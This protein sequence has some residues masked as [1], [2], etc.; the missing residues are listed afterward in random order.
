VYLSLDPEGQVYVSGEVA[1]A[2]G[3]S[4]LM[5]LLYDT[6]GQLLWETFYD[7]PAREDI[8][9]DLRADLFG[10][11]YLTGKSQSGGSGQYLTLKYE[12]MPLAPQVVLGPTGKASHVANEVL[13]RFDP[14]VVDA[15]FV[16][17]RELNFGRVDEIIT[18]PSLIFLMDSKLQANGQLGS[19]TLSRIFHSL[20]T[21]DE[22][23]T[24]VL[25][26]TVELPK[27]WSAL[28]LHIPPSPLESITDE[29]EVA[30][31][32]STIPLRYIRYAHPSYYLHL[33][34]CAPND[35]RYGNQLS[36]NN[37]DAVRTHV[38]AEQAWCF[39]DSTDAQK[40][41]P[42]VRVGIFDTGISANH[43][44]FVFGGTG[45]AG[46][47][48]DLA[49]RFVNGTQVSLQYSDPDLQGHGSKSSG[50]IAAIR[51][52]GM[53]IAGIAGGDVGKGEGEGVH[54]VNVQTFFVDALGNASAKIP[55]LADAFVWAL[56]AGPNNSPL[57]EVANHG[58]GF[59][60]NDIQVN[61]P[62]V[63]LYREVWQMAF[64]AEVTSVVSRGNAFQAAPT[65]ASSIPATFTIDSI[66]EPSFYFD[67]W[68]LSVGASDEKGNLA[69]WQK[70]GNPD[71]FSSYYKKSVDLITPGVSSRIETTNHTGGY[72]DFNGTS[73]SAPHVSGAAALL[74]SYS[75]VPL[76]PEDV[77]HLLQYGAIPKNNVDSAGWGLL[78][79][80]ASLKL[81]EQPEHRVL[82]FDT[83]LTSGAFPATPGT[84]PI[85]L[86]SDYDTISAGIYQA[87]VYQYV[88][89][90]SYN[91]GTGVSLAALPPNKPPYW[92][93]NS[94]S[95]LWGPNGTLQGGSSQ[96]VV[97]VD[98]VSF[99][100]T[101]TVSSA[102]VSGYYYEIFLSSTESVV[103]PYGAD[104]S[105]QM[106]FSL[107]AYNPEGFTT[108]VEESFLDKGLSLHIFP[109]PTTEGSTLSYELTKP[110]DVQISLTDLSG[111]ILWQ[112]HSG[113]KPQGIHRQ[114]VPSHNLSTGLYLLRFQ[115]DGFTS[116]VKL[117]KQ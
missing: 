21:Q 86:T 115:A 104:T 46:S 102:S 12:V 63:D 113:R 68:N 109:N 98:R 71:P 61:Q 37:N 43:P 32:L 73:A 93:R 13:I 23:M 91:L 78:D 27:L 108:N 84:I 15:A 47:V 1:Q 31:S 14:S 30:D 39:L 90:F 16:D 18:D 34:T 3:G 50:I 85:R 94:G 95:R 110:A 44:D 114:E 56:T 60:L 52:N 2:G 58:Y 20:D 70:P 42:D 45:F 62:N 36:L 38:N 72:S 29:H 65:A 49:Q 22:T 111:R 97:P 87:N 106:A 76:A 89:S 35:P 74:M 4:Y 88:A 33:Q 19:W 54:L 7:D 8:P 82:H 26:K 116:F 105:A 55:D 57:F 11:V 5:T 92:V 59:F 107:L 112:N 10:V 75:D 24:S 81:I 9:A 53:G 77:E 103:I 100:G 64:R 80:Y 28:R 17:N 79:A 25:G 48:V 69:E 51:N 96:Y 83:I 117:I 6:E 40:G 66:Q 101:P 41:R 67:D 99:F